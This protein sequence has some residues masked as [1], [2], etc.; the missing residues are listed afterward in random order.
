MSESTATSSQN[1]AS[2][3]P[4]IENP[5]AENAAPP[6]P[7]ASDGVDLNWVWREV[8]KRVFIKLPFSLGVADA[9]EAVV[10]ITLTD[11]AFVCGLAPR[12][13]NLSGHLQAAQ[14]RNTIENILRQAARR[15]IRFELI[16]GTSASDWQALQER[17][18]RAHSA[19]IAMAEKNIEEHH[20]D[21]ILNQ[22][23]SEMRRRITSTPD[24]MLPPVRAHLLLEIVPQLADIE[25]MLFAEQESHERRRSMARAI[26]RIASFLDVPPFTLALEIERL[27]IFDMKTKSSQIAGGAKVPG[28]GAETGSPAGAVTDSPETSPPPSEA[29]EPASEQAVSL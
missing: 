8:R 27:R 13:Y 28:D 19:V 10:P 29:T 17:Q 15:Q 4:L 26:D 3:N 23:V 22:V 9:M 7:V 20:Y 14:V 16:E 1:S 18:Q 25:E 12:D 24:R 2:Q 6:V 11:N 5:P 21:D